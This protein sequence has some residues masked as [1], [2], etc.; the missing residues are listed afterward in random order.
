MKIIVVDDEMRALQA[1]LSRLVGVRGTE[2]HFFRDDAAEI[3]AYLAKENID[4]A[5]LDVDMPKIGGAAL[6]ERLLGIDPSLKIVFVAEK[7]FAKNA[8]PGKVRA[9]TA[10]VLY[11]PFGAETLKRMLGRV[12]SKKQVI[13]AKMFDTFDCFAGG[14]KVKFSSAKSKELFA[15]LLAYKG[16]TLTMTD[17]ISQL[18]ADVAPEKSKILYRDAVWRLRRTLKEIDIPCV[19]WGRAEL[20]P[21]KSRIECDYWEYL[22]T[23]KGD[24]RGEFCKTYDWS[25]DYLAELDE[26][27]RGKDP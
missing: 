18:W 17:A 1:F 27:A 13:V 24:Y 25:V 6:A 10:G 3:C 8:L 21:D 2:Y 23:G 15:L 22:L 5:F 11:K 19:E 7:T 14:K 12:G 26:A 9:R 16:K 4:A 20:S